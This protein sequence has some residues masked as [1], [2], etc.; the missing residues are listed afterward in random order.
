MLRG[1]VLVLGA[2]VVAGGW[3]VGGTITGGLV[4]GGAPVLAAGGHCSKI[5]AVSS[6][7]AK[8]LHF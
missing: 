3:R 1:A 8:G 4:A 5:T 7:L 2:G 6:M